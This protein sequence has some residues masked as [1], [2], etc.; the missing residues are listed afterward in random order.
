MT[1]SLVQH[2][3]DALRQEIAVRYAHLSD[4]QK[5]VLVARRVADRLVDLSLQMDDLGTALRST[6]E[7]FDRIEGPVIREV[8]AQ[9]MAP[10]EITLNDRAGEVPP[11]MPKGG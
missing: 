11:A 5:D 6:K 2:L 1:I 4:G 7:I 9:P 10:I 3:K 8:K